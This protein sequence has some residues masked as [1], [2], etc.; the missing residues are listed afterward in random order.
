M[1]LPTLLA[2]TLLTITASSSPTSNHTYTNPILPGW[3]SDPT[4]AHVSEHNTTFCA[5]STFIAYPG[6]PIYASKD[7]QNWKLA[8]NAF[9]RPSQ[10]PD[11]RNTTDQQGG[12]YAPTLRYHN[13]TFYLIV[14]YLGTDIQGLLFTTTNPYNNSAWTDP[15]VFTVTGI[16]PDIFWDDDGTV[17][18]T[19]ANSGSSSGN[20]IQQYSLD[21]TTGATG[22]IHNLWNG[23]GGSSPEGPHI[24]RKD[25]YYYLMIAEGGTE[26]GHSETIARSRFR[27]GPWE[28]YP[29]NPLLT[30]RN[31]TQY[32]QTVGHADL[33]QDSVGDWWAVALS[34]RSGPAWKNYPMGRE[35]VLAPARWEEGEWP[36]VQPVRGMMSG[37]LMSEDRGIAVGEGGW[38]DQPDRVDFNP[39]SAIPAHFVYWRYPR[40]D[41][42][43]VSPEGYPNTLRLTPSF[44][45]LTG[46]PEFKPDDG[47]TLVM[48]RQTDTLFTYG[49]DI[50]FDPEIDGEEAG[51]TVFLTQEQHI[52][53]GIVLLQ[54]NLSFRF[55]VEGRGNYDGPLP[56][57]TI[58][59]PKEWQADTIRLEIQAVNDTTYAFSAAPSRNLGH[60]RVI[61]W[62]DTR[63]VS[64]GTGRFTGAL[65]GAYATKN[66]GVGYTPAYISRWRYQGQGQ[67][68]DYGRIVPSWTS[69]IAVRGYAYLSRQSGMSTLSSA[70][71]VW[72]APRMCSDLPQCFASP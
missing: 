1:R 43:V 55:R 39:G 35:T 49:V 51:V 29:R 24:F 57:Q 8:S 44:Y 4:C 34:T 7:L 59:V 10:I 14:T 32:F 56:G 66:G 58:S 31:T 52:D 40:T 9:N 67:E 19:S 11:L 27:T 6:L 38:I 21:L 65:V 26:L 47:L 53:L 12:I 28:A 16:D 18:V 30:N 50:S 71:C 15:L 45:N 22:P 17:Y 2:A 69:S 64:G 63:I 41:N 60:K 61:G 13:G 62:A 25:G 33:F 36:V 72:Y 42:F 70:S 46:T 54:N 48:R 37:P 5:T 20:H 3:H 68:I 23:T